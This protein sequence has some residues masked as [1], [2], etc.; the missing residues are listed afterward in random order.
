MVYHLRQ[1]GEEEEV[2]G[3]GEEVEE[4]RLLVV[5]WCLVLLFRLIQL[6]DPETAAQFYPGGSQGRR[7]HHHP[8]PAVRWRCLRQA[9]CANEWCLAA[10]AP[11][12]ASRC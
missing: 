2:G 8:H 6:T 10:R 3:V 4:L 1:R 5:N 9:S 11:A 7:S 12:A